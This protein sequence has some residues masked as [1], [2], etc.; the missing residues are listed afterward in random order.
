MFPGADSP[1]SAHESAHENSREPREHLA[2]DSAAKSPAESYS[3][4]GE[5][6]HCSAATGAREKNRS[7]GQ[8]YAI[9]AQ[10]RVV[11]PSISCQQKSIAALRWPALD[12][13]HPGYNG[14]PVPGLRPASPPARKA[15]AVKL[16]DAEGPH[17]SPRYTRP[18]PCSFHT[19]RQSPGHQHV[20]LRL[21]DVPVEY[22]AETSPALFLHPG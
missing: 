17:R 14:W 16:V 19:Q 12:Y 4:W 1:C 15:G 6:I 10:E 3:Q 21:N 8:R 11:W 7:K 18:A 5:A 13:C 2:T 22:I 9:I 20:P